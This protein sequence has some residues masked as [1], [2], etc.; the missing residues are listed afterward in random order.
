MDASTAV[1]A[2]M[3]E[4]IDLRI[5]SDSLA[6][7]VESL[8]AIGAQASGGILRPVYSLAWRDATAQVAEWMSNAG[9]DVYRD[10]V[11][12]VF[13][14]LAGSSDVTILT[15]SHI[16]TVPGGGRYD[17]ALGI[18][19]G[20][21]A[22]RVLRECG[23]PKQSIEVVALC[24]EEH[25]RY[26]TGFWGSRAILGLI[27]PQEPDNLR[28]Q[29]GVPI[30]EAMSQLTLDPAQI[31]SAHRRDLTAFIE[32]HVEQG[33]TLEAEHKQIGLVQSIVSLSML[34]IVV[35]GR[36]DHAGTTPMNERSD[37]GY[38]AA[39]IAREVVD[40]T[41]RLG[42]PAVATVGAWRVS[43]GAS[44]IVPSHVELLVDVRH[45]DEAAK[46]Q[47]VAAIGEAAHGI[48]KRTSVSAVVSTRADIPPARLDPGMV[49]VIERGIQAGGYSYR[50]ITSGAGHDSQLMSR[51][52]PTGMIFVPS[53]SGRSHC[54]EEFT[55]NDDCVRGAEVLAHSLYELAYE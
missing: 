9:L 52:V 53:A 41:T 36:A 54:S 1:A 15:G 28:D 55:P 32:L 37:A 39:C 50:E 22:L 26:D 11:G 20:I 13:G 12:N 38:A 29:Q 5:D 49:G 23:R 40:L 46:R 18:L 6:R 33:P 31:A 47:L 7:H 42:A 21:E 4:P 48:A 2:D 17:G 34:R 51:H 27:D 45:P 35:L 16:D 10:A 24:E 30:G 44:N 25:S 14:R 8:G 19:A 43:P 3:P